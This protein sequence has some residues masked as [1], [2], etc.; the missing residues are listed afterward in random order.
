MKRYAAISN[1]LLVQF[2]CHILF[3]FVLNLIVSD[4]FQ[5]LPKKCLDLGQVGKL[6]VFTLHV[7]DYSTQV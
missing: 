5:D 2:F 7:D 3:F 4:W 1:D 6:Y